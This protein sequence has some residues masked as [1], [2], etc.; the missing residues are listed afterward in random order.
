MSEEEGSCETLSH[1][2]E[3]HMPRGCFSLSAQAPECS[4]FSLY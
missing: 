3:C 4:K 2:G 1:L